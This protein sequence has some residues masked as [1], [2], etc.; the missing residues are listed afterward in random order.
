M[1]Q[2]LKNDNDTWFLTCSF[3]VMIN[4]DLLFALTT[5]NTWILKYELGNEFKTNNE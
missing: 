1:S 4:V 2:I 3:K 5:L